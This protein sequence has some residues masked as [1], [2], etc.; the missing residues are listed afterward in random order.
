MV[1]S[2]LPFTLKPVDEFGGLEPL[3]ELAPLSGAVWY[4][5]EAVGAGLIYTFAAGA[6]RDAAYLAADWLLDGDQLAVFVLTLQEGEDGPAFHMTFGF[7]N[8]CSARMRVPLESVNQ[9]RWR[10]P[11]E[12]AWLKP[13]CGG[14]RVDLDKVDR[15]RI[16]VLR[17]GPDAVRFCVTPVSVTVEEPAPLED[18]V[19]L[20]KGPLL[21]ELGQSTLHDWPEKPRSPEDLLARLKAQRAAA[22]GKSWPGGFSQWGGWLGHRVEATGFFRT[23]HDGAR[24]WLVDPHGFLWIA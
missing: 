2:R 5:A 10:Y 4:R 16:E 20:P 23:H 13:L 11:R 14:D 9:N 6:L 19:Q 1:T 8:A 21:D 22:A 17:K 3:E 7:L 15:M 24:W 12:G 18:D